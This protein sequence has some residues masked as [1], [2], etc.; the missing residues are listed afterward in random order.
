MVVSGGRR[1]PFTDDTQMTLFTAEGLIRANARLAD[2]GICNVPWIVHRAYCRWLV[3]QGG[4]DLGDPDLGPA[5]SGWLITNEELHES[6]APGLTCLA[7]LESGERGTPERPIND[8]KGCGGLMRVAPAG[9][10][11]GDAF[12]LGAELAALTHGHP[13]GY[14]AAGAFAEIISCLMKGG[15]LEVAVTKARQRLLEHDGHQETVA[16]IDAAVVASSDAPPSAEAVEELGAGWVAEEALA[17][18]LYC[19][20]VATDVRDGLLLA[21]N[22]SGDSDSTGSIA[23]NLFGVMGG[24]QSLPPDFLDALEHRELVVQVATDFSDAFL[25]HRSLSSERYPTF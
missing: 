4:P 14:L 20:L 16:A 1:A 21:V 7:A 3:T 23:G 19:V 5:N 24:A 17:I 13:T 6:H 11:D 22:H 2:R 12:S 18:A 9:L 15:S 8:S 25:E 10:V